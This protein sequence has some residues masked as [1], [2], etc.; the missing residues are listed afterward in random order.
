MTILSAN[1]QAI[2][3]L[4]APLL[5]GRAPGSSEILSPGE[6]TGLARCLRDLQRQPADLLASDAA[7]LQQACQA[8]VDPGRLQRLLARGFLLSQAIERWQAR[9]IWVIS[10]AD[11]GYP[12]RL[13]AR[14]REDAPAVLYGCG[15]LGILGTGGLALVGEARADASLIEFAQ[16]IGRQAGSTGKTL[17][18]GTA[19]S[20]DQAAIQG[21]SDMGGKTIGVFADNLEKATMNRDCRNQL[22][23]GKLVLVS[24]NDPGGGPSPAAF[25]QRQQLLYA[26]ADAALVVSSDLSKGD[27]WETASEQVDNQQ[28]PIFVRATGKPSAG[29]QALQEKGARPWPPLASL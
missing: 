7:G 20:L 6:Y 17:V 8:A 3:M 4:T 22:L 29:F 13:K 10:R 27:V 24:A 9:A 16:A 18:W 25:R 5:V 28:L 15:D 2:L 14:L 1:T 11:A 23:A 12:Q 19:K 21:A 26:L